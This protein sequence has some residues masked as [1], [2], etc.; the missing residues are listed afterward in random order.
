MDAEAA[1]ELLEALTASPHQ[2]AQ[3]LKCPKCNTV[4]PHQPHDAEALRDTKIYTTSSEQHHSMYALSCG[5]LLCKTDFETSGGHAGKDT[6]ASK[7][8]ACCSV[9][10]C[11]D[12]NSNAETRCSHG[13]RVVSLQEGNT[14]QCPI[15]WEEYGS[16]IALACGHLVCSDDFC[17]LG[18]H[19]G[20]DALLSLEQVRER[21]QQQIQ[22]LQATYGSQIPQLIDMLTSEEEES[23]VH[24]AL[25]LLS[26]ATACHHRD[27]SNATALVQQGGMAA[28]VQAMSRFP[29]TRVLSMVAGLFS[30]LT[31]TNHRTEQDSTINVV[32]ICN[33]GAI[34]KIAEIMVDPE[35]SVVT[36]GDL[37]YRTSELFHQSATFAA[38]IHAK[39]Q[40]PSIVQAFL[41][42]MKEE[43]GSEHASATA[44]LHAHALNAFMGLAGVTDQE[45][46]TATTRALADLDVIETIVDSMKRF[47]ND[48]YVQQKGIGA[49]CHL[50][51]GPQVGQ[52][53]VQAGAIAIVCQAMQNH[54]TDWFVQRNALNL[55][56]ATA[57]G[58]CN[59]AKKQVVKHHVLQRIHDAMLAL[60]TDSIIQEAACSALANLVKK[61][62]GL[63]VLMARSGCIE[64]VV[65]AVENHS[66]LEDAVIYQAVQVFD[67]LAKSK[68]HEV[69][70][71]LTTTDAIP[72]LQNVMRHVTYIAMA[73]MRGID[74]STLPNVN[75]FMI[76]QLEEV[77]TVTLQ[78]L[79]VQ[80]ISIWGD[81][82]YDFDDEEPEDG[83]ITSP[84]FDITS[85][86]D[87]DLTEHPLGW[88]KG[89]PHP[90]NVDYER[91]HELAEKHKTVSFITSPPDPPQVG[92]QLA[93]RISL[94]YGGRGYLYGTI[95]SL[96][97]APSDE[98][99]LRTSKLF[100]KPCPCPR[101][102]CRL[103]K[104]TSAELLAAH[105]A[106][107]GQEM[108][109]EVTLK[110]PYFQR[111]LRFA[112]LPAFFLGEDS[113][114]DAILR[115][116]E[117]G[118][119]EMSKITK[120]E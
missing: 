40:L 37:C 78:K 118:S 35:T 99:L 4:H 60:D 119:W 61:L 62:Q 80:D 26:A 112:P 23:Q 70:L 88:L 115:W 63:D 74:P 6:A 29:T 51:F 24:V 98:Q 31:C 111:K 77:L 28:V 84:P 13:A 12:K 50:S 41:H 27:P 2:Q 59:E 75:P 71:A 47:P 89:S 55:F 69:R 43:R 53:I 87:K 73:P 92:R 81:D 103:K 49:L 32:A 104:G 86:L 94:P 17:K 95:T 14:E 76:M 7:L 91:T 96:A 66:D 85:I 19:M 100:G 97:P 117:G 64:M 68:D 8:L 39:G 79:G 54:P 15:C 36:L 11:D 57:K 90:F 109:V 114:Y 83:E 44:N 16:I 38:V 106:L 56:W 30:S 101:P 18:G 72:M 21:R 67:Q 33:A 105:G 3:E 120:H 45:M 48:E 65:T 116:D 102:E 25:Y 46:E 52:K 108:R 5:H 93:I 22:Q 58:D 110:S 107:H 10:G 82:E 1:V 9:A 34:S 113:K 20:D 42:V